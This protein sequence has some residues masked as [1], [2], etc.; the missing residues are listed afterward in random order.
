MM[1]ITW[2]RG[3]MKVK[4]F[5]DKN[6]LVIFQLAKIGSLN[7]TM[8]LGSAEGFGFKNILDVFCEVGSN[9]TIF[10]AAEKF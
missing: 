9:E 8:I 4:E 2:T 3:F 6:W 10:T 1:R 7:H 5:S